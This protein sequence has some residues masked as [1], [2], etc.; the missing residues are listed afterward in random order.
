MPMRR[1]FFTW[2]EMGSQAVNIP[3]A[4][5]TTGSRHGAEEERPCLSQHSNRPCK[6]VLN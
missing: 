3:S 1:G 4:L 2:E 6:K 5:G